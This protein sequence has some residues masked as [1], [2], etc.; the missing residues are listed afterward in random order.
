MRYCGPGMSG[1]RPL[2]RGDA[3]QLNRRA[4]SVCPF[5]ARHTRLVAG[6]GWSWSNLINDLRVWLALIMPRSR[7]RV[8]LSAGA[9]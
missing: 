8:P 3:S 7:V 5:H 2:A 1:V 9:R 6:F 4:Q